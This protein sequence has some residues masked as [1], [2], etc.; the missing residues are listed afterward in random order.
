MI[1]NLD[2]LR[3]GL[4][5]FRERWGKDLLNA[6]YHVIYDARSGGV[7][8]QWW[9]TT[10]DRLSKWR[11]YRGR[12]LP[13]TKVAITEAGLQ[14]LCTIAGHFSDLASISTNE[15]SIADLDWERVGPLFA[16]ACSIKPGSPV[17]P[18]KLCH[19]LFPKLF[20]VM[21]TVATGIFEYEFYWRGMKD[22]WYRFDEKAEA[23]DILTRM[24]ESDRPLHP[25]YP[26]ETKIMELS[27]IGYNY[28]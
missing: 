27:H 7:T 24:M 22:E 13:N 26:V 12:N 28:G 10:V 25:R 17:F 8:E 11:A 18:S 21:D 16:L 2:N 1:I 3:V 4:S 19:F 14:R 23:I 9:T 5:W 20:T 6:D 15:P